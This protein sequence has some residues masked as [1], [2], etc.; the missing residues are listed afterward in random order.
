[1]VF[2][3]KLLVNASVIVCGPLVE[4]KARRFTKWDTIASNK[5]CRHF[6]NISKFI[7]GMEFPSTNDELALSGS[8]LIIYSLKQRKHE[9]TQHI[10]RHTQNDFCCS[11]H[12][13]A[14]CWSL[15]WPC[16]RSSNLSAFS[17]ALPIFSW[18]MPISLLAFRCF[19]SKGHHFG[20]NQN[21]ER[22]NNNHKIPTDIDSVILC[23]ECHRKMAVSKRSADFIAVDRFMRVSI[24]PIIVLNGMRPWQRQLAAAH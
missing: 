23:L 1:M 6:E 3:V 24:F 20:F 4:I 11:N 18:H 2:F 7:V 10:N 21:E 15:R 12:R 5:I 17:V 19:R 14:W 13:I 9:K 16:V 8:V 22:K